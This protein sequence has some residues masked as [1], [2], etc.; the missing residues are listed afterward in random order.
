[1]QQA[2]LGGGLVAGELR[3]PVILPGGGGGGV[4]VGVWVQAGV[5]LLD[6]CVGAC[7]WAV[8]SQGV[9]LGGGCRQ[10]VLL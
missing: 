6:G 4:G 8:L 5:S 1:M 10:V 3:L 9:G 2:E 7:G